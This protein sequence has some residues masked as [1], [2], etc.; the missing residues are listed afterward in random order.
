M[1][2]NLFSYIW[3]HSRREQI[4]VI[5]VVL[6]SL[7]FYYA[8]LNLPA[9]I[10]NMPIQGHGFESPGASQPFFPLSLP[11]FG[12]EVV[13]FPGIPL[14][15]LSFLI[16]LS[17]LFLTLVCINGIFK[18]QIN[19]MKGRMGER[20]L[21][22]LRYELLDRVLR[23]PIGHFRRVRPPEIASMVKDEVEPIGG[24]IGDAIE[25]PLF[26]GGQAV[27]AL[28]FILVQNFWLGLIAAFM[29]AIQSLVIP[30][31]RVPILRLGRLRQLQARDLAGRVGEIVEGISDIR[32]ND[33][34]NYERAD[35]ARRLG[36]IFFIRFELYQRKF[37][38]K[39]LNNFLAQVTPFIFY[40]LGG[41][42]AIKGQLSIGEL[43]AVIAAYKELP[44]PIKELIDW[45]LQRQDAQIKYEQVIDQFQPDG[46]V[47][48]AIQSLPEADIPPL[49]GRI[50]AS[51][52][53]AIDD[54]GARLLEGVSFDIELDSHV[55]FAGPPGQGKEA[56]AQALVRLVAVRG[57]RLILAGHDVALIGDAVIGRRV[58]YVGHDTY[59]FTGSVKDNILYGLKHEPR[60]P[61]ALSWSMRDRAELAASGNPS[62]DPFADWIDYEAAS[63]ATIEDVE[64]RIIALLPTADF[65]DDVYQFGLR[66]RIDPIATPELAALALKAREALRPRLIDPAQ[67]GLVEPFDVE[68]YNRNATLEENLLFGLPVDPNYVG[69]SLPQIQQIANLLKELDLFNPLVA[70]GREIAETMIELFR[71]LPPDHPFFEQFSFISATEMPEYQALLNRIPAGAVMGPQDAARFIALSLRYVDARHRL[72]IITEEIRIKILAARRRLQAW[73]KENAPGAIAFYDPAQFNAAASLQDNILFGRVAYGVADAQKRVGHLLSDVLDELGLKD[74]VLRAGL[75]FDAGAAG[76]RLLPG[77]RQKIALLRA[78]LKNPDLL[79]VNQGLAV[80]DAGAQSEILTR[81]LAMRSGQGVIWTVARAEGEHP[82]DHVLVF[83]QGRIAD[84]RRLR[85]GPV[86]TSEAKER[87]L[88]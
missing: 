38:V 24:F 62:F 6:A 29:I 63:A 49:K 21:R 19:T 27:T 2:Q 56:A 55:A 40:A 9:L 58:G 66:A 75:R 45:D 20:L 52:L 35:I 54:S 73:L 68:A 64:A 5:A 50:T 85:R 25:L 37:F 46:M 53:S 69:A 8:S 57:G 14:D 3:R 31:L 42:L 60:R 61:S 39:F 65:E 41:Y 36:Q 12:E 33:T 74:A 4:A 83:E 18:F 82:F 47:S 23:F 72:G 1:D 80:L 11:W 88:I 87:T 34:A 15:R 32:T 84:E 30:L 77:Q 81:V 10:V 67:G 44:A 71:G 16:A 78:L 59:V 26:A 51:D 79:V 48:A 7:P 28:L 43:V 70:A 13:I 86:K 22:R 76:R 17:V